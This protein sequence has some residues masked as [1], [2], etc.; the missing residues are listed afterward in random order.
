MA[1]AQKNK[2]E[3]SEGPYFGR[4]KGLFFK[5]EET[6]DRKYERNCQL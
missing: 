4:Q 5:A 6:G 2:G 1:S 3:S